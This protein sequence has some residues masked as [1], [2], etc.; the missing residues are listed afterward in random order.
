MAKV[1]LI[2]DHDLTREHLCEALEDVGFEVVSSDGYASGV[3]ALRAHA[4][5][6]VVANA[7]LPDGSGLDLA[8]LAT[9]RGVP[10]IITSGHPDTI[11]AL[12][13]KGIRFLTKPF[14]VQ[15]LVRA[16]RATCDGDD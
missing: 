7:M 4:F 15:D 3:S 13:A 14:D 5:D 8:D 2:E 12:E 6:Y 10:S 16:I 9:D 11:A 1:L